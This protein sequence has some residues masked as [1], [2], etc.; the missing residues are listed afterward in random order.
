MPPATDVSIGELIRLQAA[1]A[2]DRRTIAAERLLRAVALRVLSPAGQEGRKRLRAAFGEIA[3]K[4][5][6]ERAY[7][8]AARRIGPRWSL[9]RTVAW[10]GSATTAISARLVVDGIKALESLGEAW[11]AERPWSGRFDV[12]ELAAATAAAHGLRSVR[13]M[14]LRQATE[15][16][17]LV[18]CD[19]ATRDIPWSEDRVLL[20]D[21]MAE[22]VAVAWGRRTVDADIDTEAR[23]FGKSRVTPRPASTRRRSSL[24]EPHRGNRREGRRKMSSIRRGLVSMVAAAAFAALTA[25]PALADFPGTPGKI[26]GMDHNDD[27]SDHSGLADGTLFIDEGSG[28]VRAYRWGGSWCPGRELDVDQQR[29]I[30]DALRS[31]LLVLPYY[32]TGNGNERCL[33]AFGFTAKKSAID[34]VAK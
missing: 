26:V 24:Q 31:K 12:T 6:A 4:I 10:R 34:E 13:W 3:R 18:G 21:G 16:V 17:L 7:A 27:S 11:V 1:E 15:R 20:F 2:C 8:A 25:T 19:S 14:V 22:L 32:K 23:A 5:G 30:L 28:A 33:T 9:V 29:M